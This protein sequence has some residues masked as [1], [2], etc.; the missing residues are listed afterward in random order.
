[1][2]DLS[3]AVTTNGY[4]LAALAAR[5]TPGV[6]ATGLATPFAAGANFFSPERREMIER[7]LRRVDPTLRGARLRRASQQAFDFYARY[8][9]ESFR[10][11]TISK[12]VVDRRFTEDGYPQIVEALRAGNGAIVALPHL[13]GWE[14]A[15]R[16]IADRGHDITVVVE[17]LDPPELFEWFVDL[18][19][20]LGM[21]VVPLGPQAAGAVTMALRNNHIVCLLSDRDIGQSGPEVE[22]FGET[23]TLPAGPA[24]LSLRTGAPIF[25]TAV[26]FTDRFDAHLGW[27]RAPMQ[28]ERESKRLRDDVQRITQDL[29]HELE[30]LIRRAPSQWHL[31]QPNWPSDPGYSTLG[32]DVPTS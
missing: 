7:H 17:R 30:I 3:D 2:P 5:L 28:I 23:T 22:F 31:F 18:R 10:L 11:P 4:K 1:M 16:W 26:Y 24:M 25:P 29:A 14:W 19:S 32:P 20:K 9:I 15:G 12:R 13:G 27:V 6:F 21:H 8:W